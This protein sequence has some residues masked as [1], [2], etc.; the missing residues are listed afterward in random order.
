MENEKKN[1]ELIPLDRKIIQDSLLHIAQ[2]PDVFMKWVRE[3]YELFDQNF[4]TN[5]ENDRIYRKM[6]NKKSINFFNF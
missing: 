4:S 3:N 1:E 5:F 2:G 6:V